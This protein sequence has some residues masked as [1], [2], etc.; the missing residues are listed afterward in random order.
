M[1]ILSFDPLIKKCFDLPQGVR[2][3]AGYMIVKRFLRNLFKKNIFS[4]KQLVNIN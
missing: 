2:M 4:L 1:L 3:V